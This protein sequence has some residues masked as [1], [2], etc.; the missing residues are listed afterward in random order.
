MTGRKA[1]KGVVVE[2]AAAREVRR[3]I[4]GRETE[5]ERAETEGTREIAEKAGVI[6]EV[7]MKKT[8]EIAKENP[9]K[10]KMQRRK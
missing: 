6:G 1:V 7:R 10:V 2:I 3:I 8:V 9:E 5:K 4:E